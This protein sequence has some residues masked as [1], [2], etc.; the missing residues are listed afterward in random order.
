VRATSLSGQSIADHELLDILQVSRAIVDAATARE[1]S[2]GSHTRRDFP[3]TSEAF[4]GRFVLGGASPPAF[5]PL[6]EHAMRGPA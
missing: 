5:V 2:R 3:E 6:P 4:L 1:E